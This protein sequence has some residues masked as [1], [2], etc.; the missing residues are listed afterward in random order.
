[1]QTSRPS[2]APSDAKCKTQLYDEYNLYNEFLGSAEEVHTG[3]EYPLKTMQIA[4]PQSVSPYEMHFPKAREEIDNTAG[5]PSS[6]TSSKR[7]RWKSDGYHGSYVKH[8]KT[9]S[10]MAQSAD[11]FS[12]DGVWVHGT[13]A[14]AGKRG[15]A[16]RRKTLRQ[17]WV[18]TKE[19]DGASRRGSISPQ[20]INISFDDAYEAEDRARAAAAQIEQDNAAYYK[21]ILESSLGNAGADADAG[22]GSAVSPPASYGSTKVMK[23]STRSLRNI[24]KG[25]GR[26]SQARQDKQRRVEERAEFSR[27]YGGGSRPRHPPGANAMNVHRLSA[28]YQSTSGGGGG[29]GNMDAAPGANDMAL[30]KRFAR[31][32]RERF[33]RNGIKARDVNF[34][35]VQLEKYYETR[36]K[37][38]E[39]FYHFKLNEPH[40]AE[41]LKEP[42]KAL[43]GFTLMMDEVGEAFEACTFVIEDLQGRPLKSE[44]T[45]RLGIDLPTWR[46]G[47]A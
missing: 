7:Y 33:Q 35:L 24:R 30:H 6:G 45:V 47:A 36:T 3:V 42:L 44:D 26:V 8:L 18:H 39:V 19:N 12:E 22:A 23:G 2:S 16:A 41:A 4:V 32:C 5:P 37:M 9:P 13:H 14:E 29:G 10:S 15:K 1:M 17:V 40:K 38:I 21:S 20:P 43:T 11:D 25:L 27:M 28:E 34:S 46:S 31:S